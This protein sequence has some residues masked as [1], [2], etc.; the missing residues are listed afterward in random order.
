MAFP[1][2]FLWGGAIAA[3]QAEGAYLEGGKGLATCDVI[4]G[5]KDRWAEISNPAA[6]RANIEN[7]QGYFP[8][9]TASD[10]YHHYKEDIALFAEMGFKTFRLSIA[11]ARIFPNGDDAAPNEEGLAFYDSV[12][13]ECLK[14]GIE[15]LVTLSHWEMAINLTLKHNGW[16][17]RELIP[18]F[19]RYAKTVFARYKDK[20]KYWL[21]FNEINMTFH[22]PFLGSGVLID[23][24]QDHEAL[25][26]LACHNQLVASALA[27]KACH[28]MLPGAKIGSMAATMTAYPYSSRPEDT[29]E[30]MKLER[31]NYCLTDV[32]AR[33]VYPAWLKK[34]LARKGIVLNITAEDEKILRENTVD[35]VSFSYYSTSAVSTDPA[36]AENKGSGNLFGGIKNPHLKS[37]EWGWQIDPL[38]LRITLN[39]LYDRY[40]KPLFIVEN[41]LGA[42]DTLTPD[43]AINDDYRIEY[44]REHIKAVKQAI[45]KDG[46]EI[47]G[48]TTWGCLDIISAS[49]GEIS[50]RYGFIYVDKDDEGNGTLNRSRKKSF[51][52]YKDI[53]TSNGENL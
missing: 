42:K 22:A 23:Q 48:Y 36:V 12:F 24:Q 38:G 49:N 8:E 45:E 52:W 44:L 10:F 20:V 31:K 27:V 37:S 21:T 3:H 18:L 25:C 5:G 14:Y 50:K 9:H 11:W 6:I 15:P 2:N 19:E 17:S 47:W 51:F 39:F 26:F 16:S 40:Q 32:Q 34:Y 1:K 28:E 29:W 46:V 4:H 41:G 43:G 30:K 7:P 35:F 33:G 53:I 13:D